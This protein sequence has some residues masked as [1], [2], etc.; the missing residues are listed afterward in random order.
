MLFFHTA[1][2]IIP[3]SLTNNTPIKVSHM[4]NSIDSAISGYSLPRLSYCAASQ[5]PYRKTFSPSLKQHYSISESFTISYDHSPYTPL[6]KSESTSYFSSSDFINTHA[7]RTE[8]IGDAA[9]IK[10]IAEEAFTATTGKE[11]PGNILISVC[12]EEKMKELNKNW[13]P[14]IE[15]FAINTHPKMV[16]VK[17]GE[18][19]NIIVTLG[20]ELGHVISDP[21][22]NDIDE[23]AKA[24]AFE[25]AWIR[26]IKE[27]N[28]ADLGK[29][30]RIPEPAH[31]GLHNTALEFVLKEVLTKDPMDLFWDFS[32][33]NT[34]V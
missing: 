24:F 16:F 18:L 31:N 32:R 25:I 4:Y 8:F 11:L 20:H 33:K 23:E 17:K 29:N 22:D 1:F 27:K 30:L 7:G 13:H 10:E 3:D 21:L 2:L 15:G 5:N 14:G 26:A 9:E 34:S 19:A 12:S 28:I 6:K